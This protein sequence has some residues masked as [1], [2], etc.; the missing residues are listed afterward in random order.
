M[1]WTRFVAAPA[2]LLTLAFAS[3]FGGTDP[4]SASVDDFSYSSW[5]VDYYVTQ[6]EQGRALT[7]VT[8][9]LVAEFPD[10]DQNRGI[11]RGL[12][13][14]YEQAALDPRDFKV[15]NESG[16]PVPF[17]TETDDGFIAVLTGNDDYVHGPQTY[18]ISYTLS[19][20]ILAVDDGTADEF[21]WDLVDFEHQQ[22]IASFTA[23]VTFDPKVATALTGAAA[24]YFGTANSRNEC[25]ISLVGDTATISP[26]A[27]SAHEGVTAAIGLAPGTFVQPPVRLPNFLLD[28]VPWITGGVSALLGLATIIT[29]TRHVRKRR[30]FRGT[31]VAQYDV[32]RHLPPLLADHIAGHSTSPIPAEFIH[33][34]VH[35]AIRI[36]DD[37]KKAGK[38]SARPTLRLVDRD[39]VGDPLDAATIDKLFG[40]SAPGAS[41]KLPKS[42]EKFAERMQELTATGTAQAKAR[43]YFTKERV[44]VARLLSLIAAPLIAA[45]II[46]TIMAIGQRSSAASVGFLLLGLFALVGFFVGLASHE[47]HTERG[48]EAREYLLGVKEFIS[49]AE[50]DRIRILQSPTG[51]E[52]RQVDHAM[53]VDLYEKLLP[54]A[55]IFG[56]EKQW[57]KT[58]ET[59]YS[60]QP[61]YMPIWYPALML[62]GGLGNFTKDISRFTDN[63]SSS[64][65]YT[66]SSSGGSSGG[67]F[68]GGGGGGGFSGGR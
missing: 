51:A 50:A 37:P 65:S 17:E 12:P 24:C 18:V 10:V 19:D 3:F 66:S 22:D 49:V 35:G 62:H 27:L 67:G 68:A 43:G 58:L 25:E 41:V 40:S 45:H 47:V 30:A 32:P 55:M 15:T 38:K 16:Q 53:V 33:L 8:E 13:L 54:Y 9:T 2:L 14:S 60:Q 29:V 28:V 1:P 11:V 31:I 44:P 26:I 64:V 56:L 52:R 48:A 34:A 21:Y 4:A 42:D 46:L 7:H 5:D 59:T 20:N 61:G 36:E 63:M 39:A 57:A 23:S 6:D